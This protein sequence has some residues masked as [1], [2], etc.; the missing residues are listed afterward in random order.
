MT[1]RVTDNDDGTGCFA[2]GEL[3]PS[4]QWKGLLFDARA[5]RLNRAAPQGAAPG[6]EGGTGNCSSCYE[7]P[8][9][10][11]NI[12]CRCPLV[13]AARP[14]A[15]RGSRVKMQRAGHVGRRNSRQARAGSAASADDADWS[16]CSNPMPGPG[17]PASSPGLSHTP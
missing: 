6:P 17:R 9:V 14:V 11:Q 13:T 16:L 3:R 12:L 8:G 7:N 15:R 5:I 2:C 4:L 1:I 10:K